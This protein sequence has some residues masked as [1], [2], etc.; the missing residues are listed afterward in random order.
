MSDLSKYKIL[1]AIPCMGSVCADF[2]G[3]VVTLANNGNAS[4]AIESGSLVYNARNR[5][6]A[7][8]LDSEPAA[9]Y[10]FFLDSDMVFPRTAMLQLLQDAVENDLDCVTGLCFRRTMPTKP[11]IGKSLV[12]EQKDTEIISEAEDYL[13][14]PKDQLFSVACCGMACTLIK[15]SAILDVINMRRM[16]PFQPLPALGEDYSFCFFLNKLGKKIYCDSRVKCGHVGTFIFNEET[17]LRQGGDKHD[18][19]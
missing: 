17:Y 18:K 3:S 16:S 15:T 5:L 14:Y 13:D 10:I 7:R 9:D 8:A 11:T 6:V 19:N 2:F 4:M 1:I 12:W